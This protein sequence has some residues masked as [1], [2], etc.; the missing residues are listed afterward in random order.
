MPPEF[1]GPV[2]GKFQMCGAMLLCGFVT[3]FGDPEYLP[4]VYMPVIFLLAISH[5]NLLGWYELLERYHGDK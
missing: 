5:E 2:M 4:W 3:L 1:P